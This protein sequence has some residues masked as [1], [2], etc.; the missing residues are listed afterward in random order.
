[1]GSALEGKI[2]I[3]TGA[4]AGIGEA[5]ALLFASEGASLVVNDQ[6]AST[7]ASTAEAIRSAGGRAIVQVGDV[8]RRANVEACIDLAL[9][10]FGKLDVML[11]NA[12]TATAG[13]VHE[14]SDEDWRRQQEIV[15][16]SVFFGVQCAIR[17]MRDQRSGAIVNMSSGA[18]IG[19]AFRLGAY[20]ANKAAVINLTQTAAEEVAH[21]G[22]R[23]NAIT[24]GPTATAPMKAWAENHPAGEAG[25]ARSATLGRMSRPAEIAQVALFLA[26]DASSAVTGHTIQAN[27]RTAADR[28]ILDGL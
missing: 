24:P 15:L 19:G 25:F 27:P 22:I 11:N 23:V 5:S 9:S 12:A 28:S 4:G 21:L 8:S 2:A 16:D 6:D 10:E 26:S 3:V 13:F 20:G 18:G 7:A 14:L 1:M 17:A